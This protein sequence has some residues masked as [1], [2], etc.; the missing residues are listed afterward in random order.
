MSPFP[1][2]RIT[3]LLTRVPALTV[4]GSHIPQIPR[5]P[6][7]SMK[8][9]A[10]RGVAEGDKQGHVSRTDP[11]MPRP[12]GCPVRG[13]CLRNPVRPCGAGRSTRRSGVS[14]PL[15]DSRGAKHSGAGGPHAKG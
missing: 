14:V 4:S 6:A 13:R 10:I 15:P 11:V 8:R 2:L 9:A 3:G 5:Y 1:S 7:K 12:C